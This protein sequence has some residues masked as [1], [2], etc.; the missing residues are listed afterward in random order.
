MGIRVL[1]PPDA[2]SARIIITL[3]PVHRVSI[4]LTNTNYRL[5]C[6]LGGESG[7]GEFG[8]VCYAVAATCDEPARVHISERLN[9][10]TTRVF[11]LDIL[12]P[13]DAPAGSF[14]YALDLEISV[15]LAG[16]GFRAGSGSPTWGM[17]EK[18]IP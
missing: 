3:L 17:P 6:D 11:W 10:K 2:E 18:V 12:V 16:Y 15:T 9:G 14:G 5:K 8:D 1:V 7:T 13:S 4:P